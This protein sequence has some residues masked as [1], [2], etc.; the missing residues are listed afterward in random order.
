MP[1]S[2]EQKK[3]ILRDVAEKVKKAK[4]VVFAKF[5]GLGVKENENLRNKLKEE[6]KEYYVAKKTLLDLAFKEK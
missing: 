4:S 1:K 2:R 6:G 5:D 3:E